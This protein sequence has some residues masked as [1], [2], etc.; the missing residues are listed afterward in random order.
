[1]TTVITVETDGDAL[2][3][4]LQQLTAACAL[5]AA[6]VEQCVALGL[7]DVSG[8]M[9]EWVFD[10]A[11]RLRLERAWRLHRDLDLHPGALP[12]VLELLDEVEALRV[13]AAQLRARLRHWENGVE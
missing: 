1:M 11:T 2:W 8:T 12:L 6:F 7:A 9:Q 4:N 3:W 5:D 10:A 13:E